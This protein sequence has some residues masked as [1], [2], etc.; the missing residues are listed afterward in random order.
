[1]Q[2]RF[3]NCRLDPA[4]RCLFRDEREAHLTPKAFALLSALIDSRPKAISK[5]E[6]LERIW[7][8]AF[9]SDVSLARL[10]TEIRIVA[11]DDARR[12]RVIRTVHGFGYAFAG[13]VT[14]IDPSLERGSP[15]FGRC[16]LLWGSR[17]F[18]LSEGE[19]LIGRD[20]VA[21]VRLESP[22]VSRHHARIVV[23]GTSA[24]IQDLRSRNGTFVRGE[25]LTVVARLEHGDEIG[26]GPYRLTFRVSQGSGATETEEQRT[27]SM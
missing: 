27:R 17:E 13:T 22:R 16:W 19:T 15:A 3:G 23:S 21:G 11:G 24:A 18:C 7:P 1:M 4:S 20:P 6:L 9:V 8:D 2:L 26:V 5:Q 25:R 14:E 12:P 10:I